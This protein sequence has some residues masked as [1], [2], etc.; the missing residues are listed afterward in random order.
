MN[1]WG[2]FYLHAHDRL[3]TFIF[4][5]ETCFI[6]KTLLKKEM[7]RSRTISILSISTSECSICDI[8]WITLF[9]LTTRNNLKIFKKN[10]ARLIPSL[11]TCNEIDKMT[12][13]VRTGNEFILNI[14]PHLL[15]KDDDDDNDRWPERYF[16]GRKFM[17]LAPF[18]T[19][20]ALS[21]R[22]VY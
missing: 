19:T 8:L 4:I 1:L 18:V 15:D 10:L 3:P 17:P 13:V 11:G 9:K 22:D 21:A 12:A 6:V 7:Y 5:W 20:T 14:A 16:Q 2:Y